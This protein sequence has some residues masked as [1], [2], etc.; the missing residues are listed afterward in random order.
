MNLRIGLILRNIGERGGAAVYTRAILDALLQ[1]DQ[2]NEYVLAFANE[3]DRQRYGPPGCRSL[4]V[5]APCKAAWDHIAVARA[6]ERQQVDV[7]FGLKHSI[8][9]HSSAPRVMMMHG[10]DWIAFPEN[11]YLLDRLYHGALLPLYL[12][13]ADRVITVSND[14]AARITAYM[15][16]VADKLVVVPH[17]VAP[18]FHPIVD[19]ERREAVRRRYGL[20]ERFLLY[21]GQIYPHKN[22]GGILRGLARLG[23]AVPH[24][25][26][27]AGRAHFKAERDL[28]LIDE[29]GL[30]ERVRLLNWVA[31]DDLPVL[32]SLADAFVFPSLYEGFGIPLIE[33]MACGCPVL[34]SN[35]GSCPEVAGDAALCVDPAAPEA[36]AAGI[37]R[38]V[39]EPDLVDELRSRGRERARLFTW[40]NAARATLAV[41]QAAAAGLPA[42]APATTLA[43]P[44]AVRPFGRLAPEIVLGR[45]AVSGLA[46]AT[47]WFR[48]LAPSLPRPNEHRSRARRRPSNGRPGS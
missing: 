12:R 4:A 11:Y 9:L 38:L 6:F 39:R 14:S 17:G 48:R 40:E 33:A 46:A 20:P 36:I 41:L 28:R 32:Y 35:A 47:G 44:D 25:L 7:V 22:V 5:T 27:I 15:P 24:A 10:A 29:L 19:P 13:A 43:R 42:V 21:V 16:E 34:T 1:V 45:S 26:V 18:E 8:P 30:G 23:P 37:E 31:Q 3:A 2:D